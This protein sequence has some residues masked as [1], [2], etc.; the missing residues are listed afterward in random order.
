MTLDIFYDM[1]FLFL[2][3]TC[4]GITDFIV[5][6]VLR[7]ATARSIELC[8]SSFEKPKFAFGSY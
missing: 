7:L 8:L 5:E 6:S 3:C 2:T 1:T 4:L